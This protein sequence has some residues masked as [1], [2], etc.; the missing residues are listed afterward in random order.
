VIPA[1]DHKIERQ[2]PLRDCQD[3]LEEL[4]ENMR[5]QIMMAVF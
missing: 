4:K 2:M 1:E 3:F 5:L